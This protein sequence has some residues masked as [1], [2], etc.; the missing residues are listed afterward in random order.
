MINPNTSTVGVQCRHPNSKISSYHSYSEITSLAL[1]K[2]EKYYI[3]TTRPFVTF[4]FNRM[5]HTPQ[6]YRLCTL[7]KHQVR[8]TELASANRWPIYKQSRTPSELYTT[9]PP[10]KQ[11]H[12]TKSKLV[13][14][15][16]KFS[17]N[18]RT[19]VIH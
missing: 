17:I 9:F 2:S 7:S 16:M 11:N 14:S 12:V 18:V 13:Q 4:P 6:G 10:L 3:W 5:P 8:Y 1:N 19:K 15:R